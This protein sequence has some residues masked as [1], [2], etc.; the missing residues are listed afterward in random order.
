MVWST[1]STRWPD[2][3]WKAGAQPRTRQPRRSGIRKPPTP[4]MRARIGRSPAFTSRVSVFRRTTKPPLSFTSRERTGGDATSQQKVGE[5]LKAGRG[6]EQDAAAAAKYYRQ[7]AEAGRVS[8]QLALGDLYRDGEGVAADQETA[9]V[10]YGR[11][12]EELAAQARTGNPAAMERLAG[13]YQR[14]HR[15]TARRGARRPSLRSSCTARPNRRA[16]QAR[17]TGS[18]K[19][20]RA[21]RQTPPAPP[22]SIR[23]RQTKVTSVR[24]TPW[25]TCMGVAR[26]VEQ[27]GQKAVALYQKSARRGD[28]RAYCK[29]RRSV[30]QG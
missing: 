16:R 17:Q 11:A 12:A 22:S 7:A 21:T 5:F 18:T 24:A 14:G 13:L 25:H 1:P 4:A 19:A 3:T 10:W 26:G 6:T 28:T 2:S 29:A 20:L 23:W 8:A 9:E 30:R 27:D 15:A